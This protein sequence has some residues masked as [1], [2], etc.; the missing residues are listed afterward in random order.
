MATNKRLD[1]ELAVTRSGLS[2]PFRSAASSSLA[3]HLVLLTLLTTG[4]ESRRGRRTGSSGK[5][6]R[7]NESH[8][9]HH[10]AAD[11]TA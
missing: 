7:G 4:A 6:R 11:N 5:D 2:S 1:P 10:D 3:D 8:G 9:G